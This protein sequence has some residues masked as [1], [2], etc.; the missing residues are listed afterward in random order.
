VIEY[1]RSAFEVGCALR[2]LSIK[3][4]IDCS[5]MSVAAA[6]ADDVS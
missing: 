4:K 6:R 5:E 3:M 2:S 1:E